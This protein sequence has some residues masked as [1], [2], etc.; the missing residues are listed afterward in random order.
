MEVH[1]HSHSSRKKW[2]HY[3]WEF[4]ML[5]LA[6]FCG[7]LAENQREHFV[8]HQREKKFMRSLS[9]DLSQDTAELNRSI[10]E[11]K[12]ARHLQDSVL[13]FLNQFRPQDYLPLRYKFLITWSLNR[14]SVVFNEV[15]AMQLK[16]AGNLRLIRNQQTIRKISDYWTE[17]ENTKIT[18]ERYLI[19]RNRNREYNEKLFDFAEIELAEDDLIEMPDKGIKVINT[20]LKLWAEYKNNFAHCRVTTKAVI[21][22]LQKQKEIADELIKVLSKEYHLQ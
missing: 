14:F 9:Y 20:D 17:Q 22:R 1:H 15:T 13:L 11:V 18:I 16:H 21:T 2:S 7:F 12:Q 5:F 6:V 19:Y 4:F 8:E 10:A 3:F